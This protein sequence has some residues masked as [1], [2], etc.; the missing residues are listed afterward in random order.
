MY[1]SMQLKNTSQTSQY[2]CVQLKDETFQTSQ[3]RCVQLK[4]ETF[5]LSVQMCAA[6]EE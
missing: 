6:A 3:Y 2:R 4:N 5:H 1:M